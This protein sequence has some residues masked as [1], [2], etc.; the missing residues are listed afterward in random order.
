MG[1]Y[2]ARKACEVVAN[3]ERVVAIEILAACQAL[4]FARPNRTTHALEAVHTLVRG[5]VRAWDQDRIMYT[6][7][8][9]VAEL[10]KTGAIARAIRPYLDQDHASLPM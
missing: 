3:V 10:V 2:A 9:M 7:I 8:D 4:E 6:D 1:G 5:H